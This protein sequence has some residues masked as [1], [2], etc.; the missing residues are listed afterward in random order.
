[1]T[2]STFAGTSGTG[3]PATLKYFMAVSCG[4]MVANLYYCQPLLGDFVEVLIFR[5]MRL[6]GL[7]SALN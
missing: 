5:K 2:E 6:C 1:M 4:I 7:I 3:I